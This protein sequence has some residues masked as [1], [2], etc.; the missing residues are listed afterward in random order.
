M[1]DALLPAPVEKALDVLPKR[2]VDWGFRK[3]MRFGPARERIE[4]MYD[5]MLADAADGFRPYRDETTTYA[6]LP[7]QGVPRA[8]VLTTIKDLSARERETWESGHVSGAVYHGDPEHIEFLNEVYAATSQANPLHTDIWPSATKYEAEIVAMTAAMMNA[9]SSPARSGEAGSRDGHPAQT[10][11]RDRERRVVG[12]VT[13]G[14]TESLILA[15]R[16]Y[17][18][19]A[20]E[21]KGI[22]KPEVVLPVS[23]HSAFDKAEEVLGVK[24]V[25]I[26]VGPDFRGDVAAMSEAITKNTIAL[27]GSAP[28]FPHGV[29]DPIVELSELALK[30]GI[31]LHV[32]ACLGGFVL[33]WAEKLGYP[34]PPFDFRLDGV[35]SMSA[36]THKYGYAAKGTSVLLYR[37]ESLRR[38]QWFINTEWTGGLYLSPTFAGSR[39]GALSAACWAAMVATGEQ[40]YLDNT[41]R[42]LEAAKELRAVIDAQPDVRLLGDPLWVLAFASDTVDIYRVMDELHHRGW[43]LNGLQKPASIHLCTTLR[44]AQPGIADKFAEDLA[45]AVEKAR[46]TPTSSDGMAPMYGMA[47]SFPVRGAVSSMMRRYLDKV[48]EL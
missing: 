20:R 42:I 48:Y 26:P 27:V 14:G 32:D 37:G 17:R 45:A 4:A 25:R 1:S 9:P 31:G 6:R 13:S 24:M 34:V 10:D 15:I 47:G 43:A 16:T 12:S 44:H 19:W 30:H 33:P 2:A 21:T 8:E 23:A 18:D 7:E 41:K 29:V 36:D 28:G 39:P 3:A 40:G 46:A 38:Y 22:T 11:R 35:T 5:E